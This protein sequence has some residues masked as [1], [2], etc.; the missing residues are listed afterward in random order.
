MSAGLLLIYTSWKLK[1]IKNLLKHAVHP[2]SKQFKF[3]P[4][5]RKSTVQN[6]NHLTFNL[7]LTNNIGF[8]VEPGKYSCCS[9][10]SM[11]AHHI[12]TD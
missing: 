10:A 11:I 3:R 2:K 6:L 9:R 7:V 5:S 1:S 12:V 8:F 4:V